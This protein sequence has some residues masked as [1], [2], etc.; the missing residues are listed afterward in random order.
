[1]SSHPWNPRLARSS[2]IAALLAMAAIAACSLGSR[3]SQEQS[4]ASHLEGDPYGGCAYGYGGCPD[5]GVPDTW[6]ADA[7]G[8]DGGAPDASVPDTG[9]DGGVPDSSAP[10]SGVPDAGSPDSGVPDAGIPDSRLPDA[11]IPDS[12]VPDAGIPD[13][14]AADAGSDGPHDGGSGPRLTLN[15]GY[16]A[17]GGSCA[18]DS[19][20]CAGD[21]VL[22]T[23]PDACSGN[24]I[25][26]W[27]TSFGDTL[28]C[29]EAPLGHWTC[30]G[31]LAGCA[32]A[33][34]AGA[35]DP[36]EFEVVEFKKIT[37]KNTTGA[38]QDVNIIKADPKIIK[39]LL[40][41]EI[42][43][44]DKQLPNDVS[45]PAG[46]SKDLEKV[47]VLKVKGKDLWII[48]LAGGDVEFKQKK[49]DA[50]AGTAELEIVP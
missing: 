12:G 31:L 37:I 42:K 38:A 22:C 29:F 2:V 7:G 14:G 33:M 49:V 34:L 23:T 47:K 20:R 46:G 32:S 4:R 40:T 8:L 18:A 10:D 26:V 28:S 16:R 43:K 11:G 44:E 41:R 1:M 36:I 17:L 30:F 6:I 35:D 50:K 3:H 19:A 9:P 15:L 5:G 39:E 25:A 24:C 21:N 13:G 27:D 48:P 45:I